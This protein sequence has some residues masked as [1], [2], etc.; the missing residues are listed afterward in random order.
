MTLVKGLSDLESE[1]GFFEIRATEVVAKVKTTHRKN[2]WKRSLR[3]SHGAG[4]TL[5]CLQ[6]KEEREE[7]RESRLQKQDQALIG[8]TGQPLR[9]FGPESHGKP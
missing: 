4:A 5:G 3:G 2:S 7:Q 9:G 1:Y 6:S 8:Q